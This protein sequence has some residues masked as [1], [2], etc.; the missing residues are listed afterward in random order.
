MG[1][2]VS[3]VPTIRQA[4]RDNAK[5]RIDYADNDGRQT[6]R[7][8]WP[9]GL[10]LFSHRTLVCTWCELREGYRAFRPERIV[11]CTVLEEHFDPKH[12]ALMA[13][14]LGSFARSANTLQDINA[15][16]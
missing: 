11:A 12:G 2:S 8:V 5:L 15:A 4:I 3:A 9:L 16:R 7:T 6:T 10:Y 13:E 1:L 14:F